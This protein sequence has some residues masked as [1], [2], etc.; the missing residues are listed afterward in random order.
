MRNRPYYSM[1][2][3]EHPNADRIDLAALKSLFATVYRR[4]ESEGYFQEDLGYECVDAGTVLGTTGYDLAGTMLLELRKSDLSPVLSRLPDYSEHDLFDV[5]EFLFEHCSKP[6][7]REWHSWNEC[8][9]HCE[10]F[11]R[12]AGR[13]EY[14]DELNRFLHLFDRGYELT[15]N[16]ELL[17][18]PDAGLEQLVDAPLLHVDEDNVV[19]RVKAAQRKFRRH[20]ATLDERR[21]AVRD[22][23]DVLEFLRPQVKS[24]LTSKDESDLFNIANGFGIRHH[25]E[26]Q[27]TGYDRP[28]FYSWMFYYYL[29]TIHAATRL[30]ARADGAAP[31]E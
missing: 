27:R 4:L 6:T 21:D 26:Q 8:G 3:G 10:E 17:E 30:I 25:N 28:I 19:A 9:W 23:A 29:A 16:G 22:L 7:K 24:V 18:L 15:T 5:I 11:D 20:G 31:G 1:R 12:E 14:R 13:K 2:T